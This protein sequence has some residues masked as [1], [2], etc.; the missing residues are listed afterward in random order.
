MLTIHVLDTAAGR[1]A[2][3]IQVALYEIAG[4]DR[5][6]LG[7]TQTNVDGRTEAPLANPLKAG[8]YEI[9]FMVAP[10]FKTHGIASFYD[11]ITVRVRLDDTDTKVHVPLLLSPWG[12]ST[13]R[14]S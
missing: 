10:Y 7:M 5:K 14:G 3:G 4:E 11:V 2:E 13:Y 9:A 8:L 6:Q 1:P 12:Y